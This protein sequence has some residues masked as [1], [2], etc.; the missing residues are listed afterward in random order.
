MPGWLENPL[1]FNRKYSTHF[2]FKVYSPLKL[3]QVSLR[4]SLFCLTFLPQLLSTDF[5]L[6]G[7]SQKPIICSNALFE[8]RGMD[9]SL[10]PWKT[11]VL[12]CLEDPFLSKRPIFSGVQTSVASFQG[13]YKPTKQA[14]SAP[15]RLPYRTC[16]TGGVVLSQGYLHIFFRSEQVR[17]GR[18]VTFL[19]PCEG[20]SWNMLFPELPTSCEL[21]ITLR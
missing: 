2:E 13:R 11:L 10:S 12:G 1:C 9:N 5:L 15:K 20:W 17:F 18:R 16:Q 8:S 21:L 14:L 19:E 3:H 6:N 7:L 4:E